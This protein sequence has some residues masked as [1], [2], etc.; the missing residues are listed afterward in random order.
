MEG[1]QLP[2]N[3][4]REEPVDMRTSPLLLRR[5][6]SENRRNRLFLAAQELGKVV[7][8]VFLLVMLL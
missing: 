8:T 7:R 5:F 1:D 2:I 6:G 4:V 3:R